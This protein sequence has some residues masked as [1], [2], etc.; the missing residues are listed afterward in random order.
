MFNLICVYIDNKISFI[1]RQNS[2]ICVP[3]LYMSLSFEAIVGFK[4]FWGDLVYP[5]YRLHLIISF[6]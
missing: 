2:S 4:F 5:Y 3:S 6:N 1:N